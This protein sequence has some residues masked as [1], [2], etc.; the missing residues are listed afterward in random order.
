MRPLCIT[1]T[2]PGPIS[3]PQRPIALDALIMAAVAIRDGMVPVDGVEPIAIPVRH[4]GGIYLAT[5]GEYEAEEHDR[6]WINRRFP[7][8][9]AQALGESKLR[10]INVS[11]GPTKSFRIPLEVCYLRDSR[12]R[13]WCVGDRDLIC[14]LL[15][16]VTHLG[17]KRGVG[18]GEVTAWSVDEC[19]PWEGFP[20]LRDGR[21]L[22]PLPLTWPGV[23]DA[24]RGYRVLTP[25]YW[26]RWREEECL[27]PPC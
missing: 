9:E 12:M 21:P 25:P 16:I 14:A 27:V 10:R 2:V 4:E 1:A 24:D 18:K 7:L 5:T 26:Q 22:R 20:L 11:A 17:K 23:R 19:E 15:A 3:L 13:W 6:H 8:S